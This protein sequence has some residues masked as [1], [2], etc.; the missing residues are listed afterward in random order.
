MNTIGEN[1]AKENVVSVPLG[2]WFP[3]VI[4]AIIGIF[5]T[6]KANND[7]PLMSKESYLR[8]IDKILM[9]LKIKQ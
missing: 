2:M 7:S 5:L 1:I 9:F 4:L 6:I 8:V 3:S